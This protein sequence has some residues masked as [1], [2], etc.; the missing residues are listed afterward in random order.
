[1]EKL[2]CLLVLLVGCNSQVNKP[3]NSWTEALKTEFLKG[4]DLGS[5]AYQKELNADYH[6]SSYCNC[7]LNKVM[8]RYPF[9]EQGPAVLPQDFVEKTAGECLEQ[10]K[11]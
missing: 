5:D 11:P 3:K 6:P 8:E 9:V 4:C 2:I 10:L 7:F 1:M